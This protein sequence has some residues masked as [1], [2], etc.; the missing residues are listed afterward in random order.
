MEIIRNYLE[1]MFMNLPDSPEIYKAKN[2]LWQMMEDKYT[3][4]LGE[5]KSENEAVGTVIAEFGNLDELAEDLGIAQ[6]LHQESRAPQGKPFPLETVREY[7][8][9][10]ARNAFFTALGVFFCIISVCGPIFFSALAEHFDRD[11]QTRIFYV[12][13]GCSLFVLAA[14]GVGILVYSGIRISKWKNIGQEHYVTDF[15]TTEYIH[16]EMEKYKGTHALLLTVG[17]VLCI[18]S[19]IPPIIMDELSDYNEIWNYCSGGFL[20][21]MVAIGVFLIV[22]SSMK[23]GAYNTLLRLNEKD[24]IGGNYVPNQQNAPRYINESVATVM[25]VFW[26]TVTCLYLIWSFLTF[27]WYMTWIIWPIAGIIHSVMKNNL[28]K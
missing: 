10:K 18:L 8:A 5:G 20:F 11:E 3:E 22:M 13:G 25:S 23:L 14:I 12:V 27:D 9:D 15:H 7:L 24:T 1:N 26:P 17:I 19:V 16:Q 28:K 2:E 4:L 6:F 21:L